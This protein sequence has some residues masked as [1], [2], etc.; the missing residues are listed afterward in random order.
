MSLACYT[1]VVSLAF[2]MHLCCVLFFVMHFQLWGGGGSALIFVPSPLRSVFI[3][4]IFGF[5]QNGFVAISPLLHFQAESNSKHKHSFLFY[6][7]PLLSLPVGGHFSTACLKVILPTLHYLPNINMA[8][9]WGKSRS[10]Q[11]LFSSWAAF[12]CCQV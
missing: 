12:S 10:V 2:H 5:S 7:H 8:P 9:H 6:L 3:C 11:I 4:C 1:A